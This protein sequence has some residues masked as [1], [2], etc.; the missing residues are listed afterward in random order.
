MLS[1]IGIYFNQVFAQDVIYY[2]SNSNHVRQVQQRLKDWGYM[3]DGGVDGI[4]G[5]KTEEAVKKFQRYHG[6]VADGKAG[7]QTL[8]A[9]G[10]GHLIR[11]APS[12]TTYQPSRGI[13]T[14]DETYILAQVVNGEPGEPIWSGS[15]S[16]R[17]L[18]RCDILLPNTI[19][20]LFFNRCL[21]SCCRWPNVFNSWEESFKAAK[22]AWQAGTLL[23]VPY[24]YNPAV[25][26]NRW[27][28][29][30]PII[31]TIGKHVFAK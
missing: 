16:S 18:N 28:Y 6:L 12:Q 14:R 22:D 20:G 30:R 23:E 19:S 15:S 3:K 10:L 24:I 17:V 1:G 31:K 29:S 5:W 9:M 26:T 7:K 13:S 2:G 4:F 11:K 8:D 25:A 21:Y 27:I